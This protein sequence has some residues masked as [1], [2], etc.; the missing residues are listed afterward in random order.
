[1]DVHVH[2]ISNRLGW[3]NTKKPDDTQIELEKFIPSKYFNEVN[4]MLV[5]FGQQICKSKPKCNNCLLKDLCPS[6][7]VIETKKKK[8]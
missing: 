4:P 7:E 6:F 3:V 8:D 1:M 2:R 5:G